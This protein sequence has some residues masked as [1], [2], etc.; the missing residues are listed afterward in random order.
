M[1]EITLYDRGGKPVAYIA[2]EKDY[3]IYLW[4]GKPICYLHKCKLYTFDGHHIGW[5]SKGVI[6]DNE[7]YRVFCVESKSEYPQS[8]EIEKQPKRRIPLK[9]IRHLSQEKPEFK[10]YFST[11][12][13]NNNFTK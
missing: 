9:G 2:P 10:L 12:Q 3:T 4:N 6:Y 11:N 7:G 5:Y 8:S 13:I 1:E